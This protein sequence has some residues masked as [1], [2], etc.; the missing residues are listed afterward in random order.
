MYL[1]G[2][3]LKNYPDY[4]KEES[5]EYFKKTAIK[6]NFNAMTQ[7]ILDYIGDNNFYTSSS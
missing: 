3:L 5:K 4:N 2:M 1:Y 7:Y 6:G